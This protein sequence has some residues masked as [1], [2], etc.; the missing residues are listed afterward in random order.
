MN[1]FSSNDFM[2][3]FSSDDYFNFSVEIL[4]TPKKEYFVNSVDL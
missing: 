1:L 2:I 4:L 3:L